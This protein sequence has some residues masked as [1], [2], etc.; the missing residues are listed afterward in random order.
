VAWPIAMSLA[1]H[2]AQRFP[3]P[4]KNPE[5]VRLPAARPQPQPEPPFPPFPPS[6]PFPQN[7]PPDS[8]P[9]FRSVLHSHRFRSM[10]FRALDSPVAYYYLPAAP[11]REPVVLPPA[12]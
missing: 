11:C 10:L 6:L 8:A 4:A 5:P 2:S 3:L 9:Q 12:C 7:E 1:A